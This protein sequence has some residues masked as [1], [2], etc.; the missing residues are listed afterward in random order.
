MSELRFT[1]LALI[2][3][4]F[5]AC[6]T[7]PGKGGAIADF[8]N[9]QKQ[10]AQQLEEKGEL[11]QSLAVWRSLLPLGKADEET[12]RAISDLESR[13]KQKLSA[14]LREGK[15]AYNRGDSRQGD[16]YML[17]ALALQPGYKEAQQG[18]AKSFSARA[19]AQ[20]TSQ[21]PSQTKMTPQK[22]GGN[23]ASLEQQLENLYARKDYTGMLAL[24]DSTLTASNSQTSKLLRNAHIALA[25]QAENK[26]R[27]EA[28]L[29][30]VQ[31]AMILKPL[32][33][34]PLVDRSLSL[35]NK[36]S[37]Q[38]YQEGSRLMKTDIAKAVEALQKS[39]TYNPYNNNAKRK[40]LQ[41]ETLQRNLKK[42]EGAR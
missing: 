33:N 11:A 29:E 26:G 34:D 3:L 37:Q 28:A 10:T 4:L 15:R 14:N 30:H 41:A 40:M 36:L 19:R 24:S 22:T 32:P 12:A 1:A 2:C 42:I 31:S 9:A 16:Y 39:L 18:L 35:R 23:A 17:R 7:M 21:S 6:T 13:I 38:W 5:C 8:V 27:T 20:Q 25:D